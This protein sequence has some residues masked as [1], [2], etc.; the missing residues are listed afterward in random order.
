[1]SL[2]L[3]ARD[4]EI[5]MAEISR[6]LQQSGAEQSSRVE[7][8]DVAKLQRSLGPDTALVEYFSV[9]GEFLAF[10][11]TDQSIELVTGL[12]REDQVRRVLER[13]RFQINS[14]RLGPDRLR[15]HF[16]QLAGRTRHHLADLYDQVFAPIEERL[17][18]RR[19]VIVPYRD[20]HYVPFHA[21]FDGAEFVVERREVC[22]C[23]SGSVLCHCLG[24]P[25]RPPRSALLLGVPD[26]TAPKVRDEVVALSSLFHDT[27]RLLDD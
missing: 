15:D 24:L 7:P 20:L 9:Q 26:P 5:A 1:E 6:Q 21:L 12:A 25:R 3:A 8:V 17:G 19:V 27:T 13:L 2:Q 14:L 10:V 22:Y 18:H 11:I 4:R 16:Q 23:P